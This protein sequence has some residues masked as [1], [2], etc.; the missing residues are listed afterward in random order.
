MR[1]WPPYTPKRTQGALPLDPAHWQ[2]VARRTA[3]A[4]Q[5]KCGVHG[6]AMN[7]CDSLPLA[8]AP[9]YREARVTLP[10][11]RTACGMRHCCARRIVE[12]GGRRKLVCTPTRW[13]ER[14]RM[15]EAETNRVATPNTA[16]P[17]AGICIPEA[18]RSFKPETA[19]LNLSLGGFKGGY[20]LS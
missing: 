7:P 8:T 16:T 10:R 18:Q 20:S 1:E 13:A 14:Q 9:Y 6:F 12:T 17:R 15:I 4:A 2:F 5:C 3:R 19:N 11:R